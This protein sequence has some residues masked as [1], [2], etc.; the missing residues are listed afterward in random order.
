MF[1]K[2]T[3]IVERVTNNRTPYLALKDVCED[4]IIQFTFNT[5]P[6]YTKR[7]CVLRAY[8]SETR[9]T[10]KYTLIGEL[11]IK[12]DQFCQRFV[13]YDQ[14]QQLSPKEQ[15]KVDFIVKCVV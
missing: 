8:M 9:A 3:M 4:D 1:I 10:R 15:S 7:R 12:F 2:G 5:D 11:D 14:F 6:D 13:D